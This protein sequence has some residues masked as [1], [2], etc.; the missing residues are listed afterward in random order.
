MDTLAGKTAL[1]TGS[2]RGIGRGIAECLATRGALVA[3]H[4]SSSPKAAA[5]TVSTIKRAGGQAFAF[6]AELGTGGDAE[7]LWAEFDGRRREYHDDGDSGVD[8]LVNNA[9]VVIGD[10]FESTKIAD[11]DQMYAVNVRAPFFIVQHGLKWL[12]DGGRIIN[13][14]SAITRLALPEVIAYGL[15]KGALET[16]GLIL[17]KVV[18]DR[19]ITVNSVAPGYVDTDANAHW[20]RDDPE[21]WAATAA[22]STFGRVGRPDDIAEVVAFL[23]SDAARWVTGQVIDV[24]GGTRL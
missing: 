5:E 17:A 18:G 4:Y 6:C 3:V 10:H 7:R 12:R 1:V 15:T 20:L 9:A 2:S 8:I 11:F 22:K 19:G 23:V 16:F 13:I 14:T 21:A 24:S